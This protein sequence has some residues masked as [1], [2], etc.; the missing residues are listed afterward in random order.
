MDTND[1]DNLNE[2]I[3]DRVTSLT[4]R[5][6]TVEDRSRLAVWLSVGDNRDAG[7]QWLTAVGADG[8]IAESQS[9]F[10]LR[11]LIQSGLTGRGGELSG[12]SPS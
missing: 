2:L 3:A 1:S 7:H 8:T 10:A 5:T 11:R 9:E 12:F 6:W 4:G